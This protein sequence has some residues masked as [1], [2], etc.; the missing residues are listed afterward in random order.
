MSK[1][2]SKFNLDND[3]NFEEKEVKSNAKPEKKTKICSKCGCENLITSK[4]CAECGNN[5]FYDS[6]EIY[7]EVKN[8]KYCLHCKA[9][10]NIKTK[11]CP[12]CGK[13]EFVDNIEDVDKIKI[14]H[15]EREWKY[16]IRDAEDKLKNKNSEVNYLKND[17]R[18]LLK[19]Y[20]DIDE[21]YR[22]KISSMNEHITQI[23]NEQSKF[24]A[25]S[26]DEY[27]QLLI[28]KEKVVDE[29]I[30]EEKKIKERYNTVEKN[31]T[32]TNTEIEK[33]NNEIKQLKDKLANLSNK[34][35]QSTTNNLSGTRPD[36][37]HMYFGMYDNEPIK[38]T[39]LDEKRDYVYMISTDCIDSINR[40]LGKEYRSWCEKFYNNAFTQEEKRK[41]IYPLNAAGVYVAFLAHDEVIKYMFYKEKRLCGYTKLAAKLASLRNGAMSW[42]LKEN[43][44][45]NGKGDFNNTVS[46]YSFHGVRPVICI[47]KK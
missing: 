22:K 39:V 33:L 10:L 42:W 5:Q 1:F 7:N 23:K 8:T 37:N 27:K 6:I 41:M 29:Y 47:S 38:W 30:S 40:P 2:G 12:N 19:E 3:F 9:K 15:I 35:S 25:A 36:K 4:F 45:V 13:N 32:T 28:K 17:N 18:A 11:F 34:S 20:N 31:I 26:E 21:F 46:T 44:I 43:E 16:K 24:A 14:D